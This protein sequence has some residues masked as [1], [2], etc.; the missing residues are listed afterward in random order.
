MGTDSGDSFVDV[1]F[2]ESANLTHPRFE[3]AAEGQH[4]AVRYQVLAHQVEPRP[5]GAGV[6]SDLPIHRH[7]LYQE[8]AARFD[9]FGDALEDALWSRKL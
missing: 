9:E 5:N 4:P 7:I 8:P 2:A 1:D 6:A 3:F